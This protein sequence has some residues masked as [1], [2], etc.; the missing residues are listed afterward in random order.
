MNKSKGLYRHLDPAPDVSGHFLT[1]LEHNECLYR[2]DEAVQ[3]LGSHRE[4]STHL[5]GPIMRL[6]DQACQEFQA[7]TGVVYARI[8]RRSRLEALRLSL[9]D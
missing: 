5:H 3:R 7:L 8:L 1:T 6:V 4:P 2:V 9:E